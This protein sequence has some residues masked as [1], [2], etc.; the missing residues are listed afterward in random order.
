MEAADDKMMDRSRHCFRALTLAAFA[1]LS[2][3]ISAGVVRADEKPDPTPDESEQQSEI[4]LSGEHGETGHDQLALSEDPVPL[5]LDE[6]LPKRTK[7][8]LEL[9]APLLGPGKLKRGFTLP[10]GAVWTPA[11]W[12]FGTYRTSI[13]VVDF[14][15]DAEELV[16][17][18][19][20]LDLFFNLQ[21]SGTERLMIG[22][23]PLNDGRRFTTYTFQPDDASGW[24]WEGNLKVRT[25]FFEGDFG[26]I[27][28]KLD[29]MDRK[30]LDIGFAVGR[31]QIEFQDGIMFNDQI[32]SI[33]VTRNGLSLPG[34]PKIRTTFLFGWNDLHRGDAEID[35]N[36]RLF[37]V[38][39]EIDTP[40]STIEVDLAYVN[41]ELTALSG[42]D[43]LY[44]GL[45]A[46]QRFG[47]VN[48]TLRL[49]AS[50]ALDEE[51]S[52]VRDGTLLFLQ[53]S[54]S[55]RGR[56]DNVYLNGFLGI[57]H[58]T[59]VSRDPTVGGP[60][61]GT[62][63]LFAAVGLGRFP[64]ALGSFADE[65]WGLAVGYQRFWDSDRTQ[66]VIEVGGRKRTDGGTDEAAIGARVQRKLGR[67]Y[68]LQLDG[69]VTEMDDGDTRVGVRSEFRV[70]F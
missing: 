5:L 68:L 67:R 27:F 41:S 3:A 32:D 66:L 35:P 64:A 57:D 10:T 52:S 9:G 20:R 58:Y 46:T 31:Q 49:N 19:H 12:V 22:F 6:D 4:G 25:L 13:N 38:F 15:G 23:Q 36:A 48:T 61:G 69:Y 29:P 18:P 63:L 24:Q 60:L 14:G 21:L 26:E 2:A 33:G 44:W 30:G 53:L 7:P 62:G 1:V 40:R 8:L 51:S 16:E 11:L 65:S 50:Y 28:P 70:N 47:F 56:H 59:S 17:W 54:T 37:A 34:I 43:G 42:G 39:G 55:P 45:G